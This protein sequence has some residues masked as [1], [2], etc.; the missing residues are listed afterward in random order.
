MQFDLM[1]IAAAQGLAPSPA[2]LAR[3][4][5]QSAPH[6]LSLSM[7]DLHALAESRTEA[8]QNTGRV[9]FGEGVL[10]K[11]VAAFSDSPYLFQEE[12]AESL[13]RLQEMFY[14]CKSETHERIS[15]DALLLAM[16]EA[17]DGIAGG[18]LEYL[19]ETVLT[20]LARVV[21]GCDAAPETDAL[22]L[23]QEDA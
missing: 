22:D 17:F 13:A 4:N 20:E 11:L 10:P 9:E 6:G 5:E 19:E 14:R 1:H 12:Y 7:N 18:S 23:P 21:H 16:R 8:L 3:L 15:D 2:L